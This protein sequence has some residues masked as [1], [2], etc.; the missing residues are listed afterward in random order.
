MERRATPKKWCAYYVRGQEEF[1]GFLCLGNAMQPPPLA[2]TLS[3][4]FLS[5]PLHI[6]TPLPAASSP[7]PNPPSLSKALRDRGTETAV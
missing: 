2:V 6:F 3:G 4:S 5:F 1:T 7:P